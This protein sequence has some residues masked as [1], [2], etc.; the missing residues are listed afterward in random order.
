MK[1]MLMG[2]VALLGLVLGS[3]VASSPAQAAPGCPSGAICFHNTSTSNPSYDLDWADTSPGECHNLPGSANNTTSYIT[4][5]N[6]YT[7]YVY[8]SPGCLDWAGTI[9]PNTS[10]PMTGVYNNSISS[11]K[12]G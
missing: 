5:R 10:G 4:N 8:P 3:F 9:Y 1:K 11:F 7:W 6:G 2:L 12:R